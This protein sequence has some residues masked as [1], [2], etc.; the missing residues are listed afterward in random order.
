MDRGA[1]LGQI[2]RSGLSQNTS[3]LNITLLKVI[4]NAFT[5]IIDCGQHLRVGSYIEQRELAEH[6]TQKM[7]QK[8]EV[9]W[10]F[11]VVNSHL[12]TKHSFNNFTVG[13]KNPMWLRRKQMEMKS[14][15]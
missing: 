10:Q 1:A 8:E 12:R 4:S 2:R 15:G 5:S 3:D 13:Q 14:I 11:S 7:A 6:S 9:K